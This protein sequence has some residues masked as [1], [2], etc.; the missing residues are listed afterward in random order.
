[1]TVCGSCLAHEPQETLI[2]LPDVLNFT[3]AIPTEMCLQCLTAPDNC[4]VVRYEKMAGSTLVPP[5][6]TGS[7]VEQLG[8]LLP[9]L[10][11]VEGQDWKGSTTDV[12]VAGDRALHAGN[13]DTSRSQPFYILRVPFAESLPV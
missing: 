13:R 12:A 1:M 6:G 11:R 4:H 2:L 10:L 5:I 3:G 7:R 8:P 9:S